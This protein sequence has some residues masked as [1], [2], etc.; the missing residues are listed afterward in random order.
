M[1]DRGKP[2]AWTTREEIQRLRMDGATVRE[3]AAVV[4]VNKD[5]ASKYSR[6]VSDKA[7]AN[8]NGSA[9]N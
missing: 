9:M 1:A 2:L 6:Q 5:T 8:R 3:V 4:G 7:N